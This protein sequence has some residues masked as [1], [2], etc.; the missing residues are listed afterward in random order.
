MDTDD[1]CLSSVYDPDDDTVSTDDDD[2]E[3]DEAQSNEN[4]SFVILN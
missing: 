1:D 3:E 2:E 4:V